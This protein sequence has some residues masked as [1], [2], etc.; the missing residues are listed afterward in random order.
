MECI[1]KF[2][3]TTSVYELR[4]SKDYICEFQ[5]IFSLFDEKKKT[6]QILTWCSQIRLFVNFFANE[7]SHMISSGFE[8]IER[9][10]IVVNFTKTHK[11]PKK[12]GTFIIIHRVIHIFQFPEVQSVMFCEY[13]LILVFIFF[14]EV[15]IS[16]A[17]CTQF[18]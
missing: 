16:L 8:N 12:N 10:K 18:L 9:K 5:F 6:K 15:T 7:S 17:I 3:T 13:P 4:I 1:R 11:K 2:S 14:I